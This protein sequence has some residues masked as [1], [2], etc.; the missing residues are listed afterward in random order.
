MIKI[1]YGLREICSTPCLGLSIQFC[2][3][4]VPAIVV[5][6]GFLSFLASISSAKEIERSLPGNANLFA[7]FMD[8][9]PGFAWIKDLEGRYVYVNRLVI[10]K[11]SPFQSEWIGRTD[12]EIWPAEIANIYRAND[13]Q[14]MASGKAVETVEHCLVEGELRYLLVSK[15]PLLDTAGKLILVGGTSADITAL[16]RVEQEKEQLL[17]RERQ[18]EESLKLFRN[19]IDRSTDAIEVLDATTL[20]FLDCNTTAHLSLGYTREEFLSLTAYAIDPAAT[21]AAIA[22]TT[23]E[24]VKSGYAI[25]ESVH[26][27][28]DGS[29]FPVEI[30][31]KTIRLDRDYR[32]AVIRDI[33]ERKQTEEALRRAE[34]NYRDIF[35]NAGEGIFQTTPEGKY[36]AANPALARMHG[37]DSPEELIRTR[38]DIPREIYVDPKRREEFTRLIETDGIVREFEQEMIRKDGSIIWVTVNAR[39]VRDAQGEVL[40]YE[41]TVQDI[42]ERK[43]AEEALR[44]SE[45]RYRELFENAKDAYYVH[46]LSGRYIS[47][48]RAAEKLSGRSREDIIGRRFTDFIAP[49]QVGVITQRLCEKLIDEGETTYE[50]ELIASDGRRVPI[51]VSSRLIIE[52]GLGVRIQGAARDIT[53]R[54]HAEQA[55]RQSEDRFSKAFHSS[56][57]AL[58]IG[59]LEDG[60][61]LEVNAAFSRMTGFT[62]DES[63]GQTTLELGL[64]T[65]GYRRGMTEALKNHGAVDNLDIQFRKKSGETRDGLLSAELIHL[66]TGPCVLGIGQD[67]TERN[68]A[69]RARQSYPRQLI[70]AQEAE[71]QSIARELHDQI[72]QVLTA[73]H[74]NLE[75][76]RKTCGSSDT[77]AL[78]NEAL[79]I[80]DGA[81]DQVRDLSFELRPSL[82]DDLGLAAALRWYADR[83]AYRAEIAVT[84]NICLPENVTRLR[85]ELETACFRIVQEALTNV[86]RHANAKSVIINLH[87]S[88]DEIRLSIKDDGDGFKPD[89]HFTTHLGL[90]GM[91]E[92]ALTVGGCLEIISSPQRGTEIRAIFPR[93]AKID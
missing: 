49:E 54:K 78:V 67:V 55:L 6:G 70:E 36:I 81:V 86:T 35:E 44:N 41:G 2:L 57:V 65:A 29:T 12:A 74:L 89:T 84:T 16:K 61:L 8:N 82:L 93:E 22:R 52:N 53:E 9:L 13:L 51:E 26:R 5:G 19:L 79:K 62:R 42:T 58:T 87:C 1:F 59:S 60:R 21:A 3:R 25:F 34:Q 24:M 83:F 27:R 32:L 72:G 39:V 28:K 43:R 76:V 46:D 75:T 37:F 11:L 85:P 92:R 88:K 66:D 23:E 17:Q 77:T 48:N 90:R 91:R 71:R 80:V 38:T 40:F 7:A 10:E 20:R 14:V 56:P 68:R 63:I 50:T 45:E 64:W 15:F 18:T 33:T 4:G 30:N 73:V 69:E 31:A 47:V